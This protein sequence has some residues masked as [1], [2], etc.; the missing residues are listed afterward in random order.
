MVEQTK[1]TR[2]RLYLLSPK[3]NLTEFDHLKL[4]MDIRLNYLEFKKIESIYE[5][6]SFERS[7]AKELLA[8]LG[9]VLSEEYKLD[10]RFTILQHGFLT[11]RGIT[12]LNTMRKRKMLVMK[13]F[14]SAQAK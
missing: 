10:N 11:D 3:K 7:M 1:N 13:D 8:K 9:V 6:A 4:M 14:L 2:N 12:E 5:S